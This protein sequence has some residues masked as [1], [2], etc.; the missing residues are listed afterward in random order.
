[1]TSNAGAKNI[2]AP[3]RLGFVAVENEEQ[4]YDKMKKGVM[5]EVK[6]IFKPEFLNRIDETIVFHT[7]N[8][9]NLKQIVSLMSKTVIERAKENMQ[10][11]LSFS[12]EAISLIAT[13]GYD[14]AYGARPLRR[15]IQ[16]K[17]E[18]FFAE[19]YLEGKFQKGDKIKINVE[20]KN[21]VLQKVEETNC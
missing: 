19:Q 6:Q 7:L 15:A 17:I 20:D 2:A 16:S 3:K 10:I 21:F 4:N 8:Q 1:M 13:E 5:E 9:E 11:E 18:N 12:E 14:Q